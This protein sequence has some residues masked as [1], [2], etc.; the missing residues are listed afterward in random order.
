M[1]LRGTLTATNGFYAGV[2]TN[3][4]GGIN[5]YPSATTNIAP[6]NTPRHAFGYLGFQGSQVI[7]VVSDGVYVNVVSNGVA[8][9]RVLTN[10]FTYNAVGGFLT[11]TF[12]GYYGITIG[13]TGAGD[14]GV[15]GKEYELECF[16]NGI[17]EEYLSS[18]CTASSAGTFY[19]FNTSGTLYLAANS[20]L[21]LRIKEVGSVIDPTLTRYFLKVGAP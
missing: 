5:G 14:V 10:G 4:M 3:V 1:V 20:S 21:E 7:D 11:N 19:R 6:M 8:Y 12:A 18:S 2:V 9:N 15:N 13:A 16:V 17:A